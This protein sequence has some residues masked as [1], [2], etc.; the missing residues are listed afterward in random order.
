MTLQTPDKLRLTQ[1]SHRLEVSQL[2]PTQHTVM[3][4][5]PPCYPSQPLPPML[6]PSDVLGYQSTPSS[7]NSYGN[8]PAYDQFH[9]EAHHQL[10]YAST[11][12]STCDSTYD[13][14]YD[15][16]YE[17]TYDSPRGLSQSPAYPT[18]SFIPM[19]A[20][21]SRPSTAPKP[22]PNPAPETTVTSISTPS[23]KR[24]RGRKPKAKPVEVPVSQTSGA[25]SLA[26]PNAE[27]E[28][29]RYWSLHK[30][31]HD[32]A[33]YSILVEWVIIPGNYNR[34]R[35]K[36]SKKK[37]IADEILGFL[38]ERGI[39]DRNAES[40]YSQVRAM[41]KKYRLANDEKRKTGGGL[42]GYSGEKPFNEKIEEI[43]PHF[44]ELEVVMADRPSATPLDTIDSMAD[45]DEASSMEA[46]RLPQ[47]NS[48][49][50]DLDLDDGIMS[51]ETADTDD[52]GFAI[53]APL[54]HKA[55]MD[56]INAADKATNLRPEKRQRALSVSQDKTSDS[57]CSK[58]DVKKARNP[59]AGRF[60]TAI[61]IDSAP[62][63]PPTSRKGASQSST[64]DLF[65]FQEKASQQRD[66]LIK[67]QQD[68]AKGQTE[69]GKDMGTAMKSMA[70]TLKAIVTPDQTEAEMQ[71]LKLK[72]MVKLQ[73]AELMDKALERKSKLVERFVLSGLTIADANALA[74]QMISDAEKNVAQMQELSPGK[75]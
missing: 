37:E 66:D 22:A 41:E 32:Q 62:S 51:N 30:N 69:A 38:I 3:D 63:S 12:D 34:W 33:A 52:D 18:S 31:E 24:K 49:V 20:F 57:M 14:T 29:H 60:L 10:P 56:A 13:A 46:L 16:T 47:K 75:E 39:T 40:C 58:L 68:V 7:H 54:N 17:S 72:H 23:E 65:K 71:R 2:L 73:E 67:I 28:Y 42:I 6:P 43:C 53:P 44:Y 45:L 19:P 21:Q 25:D 48:T 27:A 5:R 9:Y 36:E 26:E 8:Q 35:A 59:N 74:D 70:E 50:I 55:L 1:I 11:Y 15:S 64:Q 61:G 4:Q